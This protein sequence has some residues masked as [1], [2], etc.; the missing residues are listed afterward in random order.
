MVQGGDKTR[1]GPGLSWNMRTDL[2]NI[3]SGIFTK[4][5]EWGLWKD[6]NP[7]TAVSVGRKRTVRQHRKL[8]VEET[9]KLLDAL[10]RDVRI[11]CEVAILHPPN[12]RSAR[13]PMEAHRPRP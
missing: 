10:P 1:I 5:I 4:A 6:P 11:I 2:R 12:L 3:L 9:R 8:T 13:P 7:V